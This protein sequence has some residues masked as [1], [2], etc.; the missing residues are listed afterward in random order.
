MAKRRPVF[1]VYPPSQWTP[2][3]TARSRKL[4]IQ[5]G[6]YDTEAEAREVADKVNRTVTL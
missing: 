3:W 5:Y 6:P 1:E 4:G 2:G